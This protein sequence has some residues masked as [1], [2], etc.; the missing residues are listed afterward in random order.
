MTFIK[1]F[2]LIKKKIASFDA[3][4]IEEKIAMQVNMVDDDCGGAFYIETENGTL[5]IEPY[6]YNDRTVMLTLKAV[7]I[8]ALADKKASID[9][10]VAGGDVTVEGNIDHARAIFMLKK[11]AAKR[12]AKKTGDK[13][14]KTAETKTEKKTVKKA[15]KPSSK[16]SNKIAEKKETKTTS[17]TAKKAEK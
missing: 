11:P 5:S 15:E 2:E 12:S 16:S 7:D 10:L 6:D 9:E 8:T 13:A 4:A 3:S 17:K 14:V 1:K